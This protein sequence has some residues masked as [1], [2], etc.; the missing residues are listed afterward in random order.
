MV[1]PSLLTDSQKLPL[2]EIIS[3]SIMGVVE[4]NVTQNSYLVILS[5]LE[6]CISNKNPEKYKLLDR[7]LEKLGANPTTRDH[8]Q[9][10][11]HTLN[12]LTT[13]LSGD[14]PYF[15]KEY[16]NVIKL[17]ADRTQMAY[18]TLF[19]YNRDICEAAIATIKEYRPKL[20]VAGPAE[21]RDVKKEFTDHLAVKVMCYQKESAA[22]AVV[23]SEGGMT[24]IPGTGEGG[25]QSNSS[26]TESSNSYK[27]QNLVSSQEAHCGNE[28]GRAQ[29][30]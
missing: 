13:Y 14:S 21:F 8:L 6:E 10:P 30:V 17:G 18:E 23:P 19:S 22:E 4:F 12:M 24:G 25:L 16:K 1:N 5:T 27:F 3:D 9:I 7:K 26:A 28:K 20:E 29:G 11:L 15:Y 2:A